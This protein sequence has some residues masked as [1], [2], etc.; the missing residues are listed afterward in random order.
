MSIHGEGRALRGQGVPVLH[1]RAGWQAHGSPGMPCLRAWAPDHHVTKHSAPHASRPRP[2]QVTNEPCRG[3]GE[4][5][6]CVV[7]VTG[8]RQQRP[9]W[10]TAAF[11]AGWLCS[12][13]TGRWDRALGW[14]A[15][16]CPGQ[17]CC[18]FCSWLWT[19]PSVGC[20]GGRAGHCG[21]EGGWG[22]VC[23][24][25]AVPHC[26][27]TSAAWGTTAGQ[28]PQ[29]A[30]ACWRCPCAGSAGTWCPSALLPPTD[31]DETSFV[32]LFIFRWAVP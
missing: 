19:D 17:P 10:A 2:S 9:A 27:R 3:V 1:E 22:P 15:G 6:T 31:S 32:I 5:S 4:A 29:G 12:A 16:T 20:P 21:D 28:R 25:P 8:W 23:P 24:S 30:S 26:P 18:W 13:G 7:P 11:L 14:G